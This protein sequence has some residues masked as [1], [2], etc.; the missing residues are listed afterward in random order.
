MS[1]STQP[2]FAW[3]QSQNC[4]Y[5]TLF[6]SGLKVMTTSRPSSVIVGPSALSPDDSESPN[7]PEKRGHV[8]NASYPQRQFPHTAL[9]KLATHEQL[10]DRPD[11]HRAG[12]HPTMRRHSPLPRSIPSS[13]ETR[14][15]V[16]P[17][18]RTPR[19]P[20]NSRRDSFS[21]DDTERNPLSSFLSLT[22]SPTESSIDLASRRDRRASIQTVPL[23]P[24][25]T[26]TASRRRSV[27]SAADLYMSTLDD[28]GEK[29]ASVFDDV[30]GWSDDVLGDWRQMLDSAFQDDR[31]FLITSY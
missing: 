6:N 22:T 15:A 28:R 3:P 21:S 24:K 11:R 8:R 19:T 31:S 4:G 30:G 16:S 17:L 14:Y 18:P 29:N 2:A 20:R 12:P 25:S 7:V 13:W 26:N 1:T 5:S 10:V 23:P 9:P 27:M